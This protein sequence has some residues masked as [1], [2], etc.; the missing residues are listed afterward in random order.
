[1]KEIFRNNGRFSTDFQS[2]KI[3]VSVIATL[4]LLCLLSGC[5]HVENAKDLYRFAG[6]HYGEHKGAC[7]N[8]EE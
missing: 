8:F 1:M 4:M 3:G 7:S 2:G 5:G 6:E